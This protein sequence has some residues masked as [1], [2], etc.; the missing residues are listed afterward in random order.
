MYD[1][2]GKTA[3]ERIVRQYCGGPEKF[4]FQSVNLRS[5]GYF[6]SRVVAA[7]SGE[8]HVETLRFGFK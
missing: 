4:V 2:N 7:G 6:L 3:W 1:I 5:C 8:K